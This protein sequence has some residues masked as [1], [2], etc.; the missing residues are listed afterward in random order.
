MRFIPIGSRLSTE[1]CTSAPNPVRTG[2]FIP[3][4]SRLSTETVKEKNGI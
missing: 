4:G 3:I 1:T 2:R